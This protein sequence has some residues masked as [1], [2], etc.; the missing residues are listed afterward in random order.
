LYAWNGERF[1]FQ[2]DCLWAAPIG[3]QFAQG[4]S[5]PT[6]EWEY[7]KLDG[8]RIRPKD[9]QYILQ[10]TEE[11]WEAAYFDTLALMAV[12]HPQGIDVYS[13]EKVGPAEL[14]QHRIYTVQNK[15]QPRTVVDQLG[16][17][18][19][20][21]V[22]KR[23]E[24]YARCW[25]IGFNQ[26]LVETHWLEIDM[27]DSDSKENDA[28]LYMTG[29]V[30]PTCTSLN[31]AMTENPNRPRLSPPSIQ[32]PNASGE[33]QEVMPYAGFPGGKTKTIAI[34]LSGK[35]L[36]DD[37]RVR[38]VTNMELCW[39]EVFYTRGE[40]MIQES[41]YRVH[42]LQMTKADLHF[43]GFSE[44]VPRPGNAP[45]YYDYN[46]VSK[47][48]LWPPM[49]GE[50][51][52]Y[53][54][55]QE[56]LVEADD[57]QVVLGAGDELTVAFS[58]DCPELPDGWVRDFILYNV[59]WDKDADLNTVHGQSIEPLPFRSMT[60]YPYAPDQSF[61]DTP[62]HREFLKR[63][64]SRTQDTQDFWNQIRDAL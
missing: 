60:K 56:L 7:L 22:S 28:I 53:G 27:N 32:V 47:E 30:F 59:G 4:V 23:D 9:G 48:S 50:L 54:T 51:T 19:S 12:D 8:R 41:L 52:R 13:N 43:R 40:T 38:V 5:A 55:V 18:Q 26:G 25:S 62:K 34:D 37:H 45:K 21:L 15:R 44:M 2:T 17:D 31:L 14:A 24:Q 16:Q 10:I 63:F 1:E 42:P 29:W 11:L 35:F 46:R 49:S 20:T 33:W 57:L 64:Q 39:D 6:R 36:C 3:L 58:A 61:P